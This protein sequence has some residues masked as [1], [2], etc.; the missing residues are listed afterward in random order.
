MIVAATVAATSLIGLPLGV[1]LHRHRRGQPR[2]FAV[3]NLVQTIPSIALFG[4][5]M[6][7]LAV[8]VQH[9]P[10]W[11][12]WGVKGVGMTPA[13]MALTLY[14]LLPLVRNVC[15]G[16]EQVPQGVREAALGMGLSR[17]QRLWQVELP[18]ALPVLWSGYSVMV[19]QAIGLTAVAALIGAG[20][21]GA[22][23]FE[24]LFSSA[25]DLVML[26]VIPIVM[27]SWAAQALGAALAGVHPAAEL[28]P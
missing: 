27:L 7:A 3:L 14:S 13:V 20:G 19:V 18:L 26:A 2:V 17:I 15:A 10:V 4:V 28:R 25:L 12:R 11:G 23:M 6:A 21:L 9:F 16:L 24:G 5:L 1:M 8:L 22:L